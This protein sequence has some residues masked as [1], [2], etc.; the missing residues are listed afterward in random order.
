MDDHRRENIPARLRNGTSRSASPTRLRAMMTLSRSWIR[1]APCSA[2]TS[3]AREHPSL[4]NPNKASP[5]NG[6]LLFFRVDD[7]D[8]LPLP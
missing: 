5:G 4:M 7:Y 1:M 2:S 6:L 8:G 3:G